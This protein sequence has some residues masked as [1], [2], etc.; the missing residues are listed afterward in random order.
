MFVSKGFIYPIE[1]LVFPIVQESASYG[2]DLCAF[3]LKDFWE[4]QMDNVWD[5]FPVDKIKFNK[6]TNAY[7]LRVS[8]ETQIT[9]AY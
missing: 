3:A 9:Y 1:G 2:M 7:A 5:Q 8:R 6:E 4:F